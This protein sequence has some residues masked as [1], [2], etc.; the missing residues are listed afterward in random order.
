MNN[1]NKSLPLNKDPIFLKKENFPWFLENLWRDAGIISLAISLMT[2]CIY[3]LRFFKND[4]DFT[5]LFSRNFSVSYKD[6]KM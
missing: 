1:M 3:I 4:I 2:I 6:H 5:P